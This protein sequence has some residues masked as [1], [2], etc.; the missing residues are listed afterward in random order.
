[1]MR[2][3]RLIG[4]ICWA[5]NT[6]LLRLCDGD[7]FF[8]RFFFVCVC[9]CVGCVHCAIY[10]IGVVK[11]YCVPGWKAIDVAVIGARKVNEHLLS[12]R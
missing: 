8:A 7:L 1:M 4:D 10:M 12:S 11:N 3:R 5:N 6:H 9:F 2:I